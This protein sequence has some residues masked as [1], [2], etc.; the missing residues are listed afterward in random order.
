MPIGPVGK[1]VGPRALFGLGAVCGRSECCS[2]S[3]FTPSQSTGTR[4][5]RIGRGRL[6][7]VG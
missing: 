7:L 4:I 6:V 3:F 2:Y 1:S 5:V